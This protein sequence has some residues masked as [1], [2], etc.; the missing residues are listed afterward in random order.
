MN[1]I[2][3]N[4]RYGKDNKSGWENFDGDKANLYCSMGRYDSA[5]AISNR[6]DSF[7]PVGIFPRKVR[8]LGE[9]YLNGTKE[10]DKAIKE[11]I[12]VRDT[13]VIYMP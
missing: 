7:V 6:L 5:I 8:M 4:E 1:Y 13:V 10:Y 2:L 9:I 11:F 12:R 3:E